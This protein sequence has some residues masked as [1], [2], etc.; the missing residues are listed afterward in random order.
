[1][2]IKLASHPAREYISRMILKRKQELLSMRF[3]DLTLEDKEELRFL[4]TSPISDL[5]EED[6]P[7]S[8]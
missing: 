6:E 5:Y 3:I 2:S 1:M 4:I 7:D 8:L